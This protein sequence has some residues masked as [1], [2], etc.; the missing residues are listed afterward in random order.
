MPKRHSIS[1]RKKPLFLVEI[2]T[3][4]HDY[5]TDISE[6]YNVKIA[7]YR[8]GSVKAVFSPPGRKKYKKTFPD[9]ESFREYCRENEVFLNGQ[10]PA[11][12]G[13]DNPPSGI[14][15]SAPF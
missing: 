7:Q 8:D 1:T 12:T 4:L 6:E 10:E 9:M 3:K 11:P 2:S 13:R 14:G 5:E 15:K